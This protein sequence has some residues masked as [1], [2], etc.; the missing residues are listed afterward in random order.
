MNKKNNK[1]SFTW[2]QRST[3]D[4]ERVGVMY[5]FKRCSVNH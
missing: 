5:C 1:I 2:E 3:Y 4:T